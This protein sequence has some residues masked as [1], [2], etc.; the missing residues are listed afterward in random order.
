MSKYNYDTPYSVFVNLS[1]QKTTICTGAR[2]WG[3]KFLG[4]TM[5]EMRD[6][7]CLEDKDYNPSWGIWLLVTFGAEMD[8]IM[9]K[10]LMGSIKDAMAAFGLYLT[11]P[12]LTDEEDSLLE[13]KFK[14][15]LPTAEAEL[16][17][18]IVT[19]AKWQ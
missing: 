4:K 1:K 13:E 8:G 5:A 16:E 2:A 15:K 18:G 19:R 10:R 17:K 12:W 9:R 6:A 11:L 7:K 14:G 3:K